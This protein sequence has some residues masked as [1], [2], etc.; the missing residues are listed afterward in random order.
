MLK[1]LILSASDANDLGISKMQDLQFYVDFNSPY[2]VPGKL[3][4]YAK[5]NQVQI[6]S[7]PVV[8]T[9]PHVP[10]TVAGSFNGSSHYIFDSIDPSNGVTDYTL[11]GW[12][13]PAVKGTSV[14]PIIA[15]GTAINNSSTNKY[16]YI[17][18]GS[19]GNWHAV[20]GYGGNQ[21][22]TT[23][24]VTDTWHHICVQRNGTTARIFLNG[25]LIFTFSHTD[26]LIGT[27]FYMGSYAGG[28]LRYFNGL[29]RSMALCYS[30]CYPISGFT[31][32][33]ILHEY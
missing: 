13:R 7:V 12:V 5:R 20:T 2:N 30:A 1:N 28:T 18:V 10:G 25:N 23:P 6:G 17:S 22:S 24:V 26:E 14:N 19:R 29:I 21:I 8:S 15:G 11:Q 16:K 33:T 31:P 9:T 3:F 32:P 27:D 4:N